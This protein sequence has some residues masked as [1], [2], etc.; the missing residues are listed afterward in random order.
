MTLEHIDMTATVMSYCMCCP[1][2]GRPL[3]HDCLRDLLVRVAVRVSIVQCQGMLRSPWSC[4]IICD[5]AF[6]GR[7][8]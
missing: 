2:M 8:G 4:I 3:L 7:A 6:L 5:H 1:N